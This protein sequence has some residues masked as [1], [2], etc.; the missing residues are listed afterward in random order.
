MMG[1][2]VLSVGYFDAY[3]SKAQK[4]RRLLVE[5]MDQIFEETDFII[6]PTT[7]D[8]AWKIGEKMADPVEMYLSDVYTVLANLCGLPCISIPL[9]HPSATLSFG[10]QILSN[11]FDDHTIL[12]IAGNI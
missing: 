6:L 2:F 4:I 8:V 3:Y 12:E 5:R 9:S 7:T 11:K 10:M 1:S